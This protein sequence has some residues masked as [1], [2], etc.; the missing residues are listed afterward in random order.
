MGQEVGNP[1]LAP[2]LPW[3][4][5]LMLFEQGAEH[6]KLHLAVTTEQQSIT[7]DMTS[8]VYHWDGKNELSNRR[9]ESWVWARL[10]AH[11]GMGEMSKLR[12]N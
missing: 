12:H 10:W 5:E 1:S 7:R 9:K 4:D 3:Q 6:Q 11:S 2:L 8:E